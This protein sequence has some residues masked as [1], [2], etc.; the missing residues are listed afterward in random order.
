MSARGEDEAWMAVRNSCE[1]EVETEV[2]G[3][4]FRLSALGVV[5]VWMNIV[6]TEQRAAGTETE[7]I[8][9]LGGWT[10]RR[11]EKDGERGKKGGRRTLTL[12]C[13]DCWSRRKAW[14]GRRG[15]EG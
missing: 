6:R 1:P 5:S 10:R 9:Q 15:R 11:A 7:M 12:P 14:S 4:N 2:P 13:C 8:G 3:T